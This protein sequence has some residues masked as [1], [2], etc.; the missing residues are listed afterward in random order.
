[1]CAFKLRETAEWE[2][3]EPAQA[4]SNSL[5]VEILTINGSPTNELCAPRGGRQRPLYNVNVL[6]LSR[7]L[8]GP[9]AGRTLAGQYSAF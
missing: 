5:V 1:M 8:A 3:T 4:L 7:V 9:V 6:D 2:K